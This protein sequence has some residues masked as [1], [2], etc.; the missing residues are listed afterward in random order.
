MR[1]RRSHRVALRTATAVAA[2]AAALVLHLLT[3]GDAFGSIT[4]SA[5][6]SEAV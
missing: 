5:G 3:K 1:F 2:A 4:V 6:D